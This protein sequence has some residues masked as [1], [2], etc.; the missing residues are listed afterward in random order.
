VNHNSPDRLRYWW[1]LRQGLDSS[2]TGVAPA[3]I[4]GRAGWARSVGGASPYLTLFSRGG[5]SREAIDAAVAALEIHELPSARGCTCVV[6]AADY[7]LALQAAAPFA[8]SEMSVARKL[9]ATE[10]EIERLCERVLNVLESG[11]LDPEA[12]RSAAG[13]AVKNFGPE[14]QKKGL[15]TTMPV[16]LGRLQVRGQ[17]RR[18]P[19]NGRLDQ[20]RC[21]YALW[22]P[23]P[24]GESRLS[25][26]QI[27]TELARRYFRW[28]GPAT[29]AEFQWFSGLGV[30][31]AKASLASLDLV[32]LE[33]SS[34]RLLFAEDRE[35]LASLNVPTQ[36]RYS[37]IGSLDSIS[38]LRRDLRGLLAEE[39]LDRPVMED[40]KVRPLGGLAD[41]PS[42]AILDRGRVV[43]LWEYDPYGD[44][45]VAWMSFQKPDAAMVAAVAQTEAWIRAQ[46]GDV[47]S[48]SL[49]SPKS[50]APR[51][52]KLR[53]RA[54]G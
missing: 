49:D 42:N 4:L 33:E 28:I 14:G 46:L 22:S 8:D 34:N 50:R 48:F 11:S 27:G 45:A 54:A 52:A 1:W 40:N 25:T 3:G 20:Q 47:R 5:W 24:I 44:G 19:I 16:A 39:D 41:L 35:A 32:P 51:I 37:L 43:G 23:G 12:I 31:A 53:E 30:K 2:L 38:L 7:A 18:V 21:R 17:I 6:P 13:D 26:E 15:S 9:G 10:D 29:L 36:P